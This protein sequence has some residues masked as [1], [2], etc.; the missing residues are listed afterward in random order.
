MFEFGIEVKDKITGF[1]GI[2]TGKCSYIT[3]CDQY[4]VQPEVDKEGKS[5]DPKWID[6]PRLILIPDGKK[7]KLE[8]EIT[9]PG[10]CDPAPIK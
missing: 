4:L 6:E 9:D 7:I 2:V 1:K 8:S 5:E 3:G 10:P